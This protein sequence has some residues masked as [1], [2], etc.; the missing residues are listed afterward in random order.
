MKCPICDEEAGDILEVTR[1]V[2]EKHPEWPQ[3]YKSKSY[4]R[5]VIFQKNDK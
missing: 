5:R 3:K 2:D 1:H 4:L